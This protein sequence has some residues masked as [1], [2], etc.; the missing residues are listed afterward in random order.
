[1]TDQTDLEISSTDIAI[2]GM[3]GRFPGAADVAE[4]WTTI[5]AG[6]SGI[7]RFTDAELRAAGVA[8]QLLADPSYVKAGAVI[9]G[10]ELFDADFFGVGPREAQILDPQQRLYLEHNW[11]ALEDAGCDPTRFDGAIGVFGGSAWSSYLQHN[12]MPSPTATAMGELVVGLANDKDSLTT[13]VAHTLGLTGPAFSIQSYCSTSLVAVC[14]ASTSLAN[15]ECDLALAGGV[16]VNVPHQVGYLYSEGGIAPPDA[17][18]R[19]FDAAG[20]GAV[21]GSGVG[22]V[23]LR[24][25]SDAVAAGDRI[26]AVIRG[27]AVNNDGG[28]KVGFTAPG[29]QGQAAVIAEALSSADLSAADI[30]YIEA[31]GTG[32]ALGDASEL[33]ALQQVF[34]GQDCLIGS[35][36]TNFGHLDRAAGVTGL[37]KTTLALHRSEIPPTRNLVQ[38][39]PQ[40]AAGEA[41]LEVVTELRS[42]PR[43][44]G[45]VR[46][47][48]VSAFGIGGTNAH[49]VLEEAPVR[50]RPE[51]AARPELLV[52]SARTA[53]AA[54]ARTDG[55][56]AHLAERLADN[57]TGD[58]TGGDQLCDVAHTLQVG[59]RVFEHRRVLVASTTAQ[60]VL[61][62]SE[63]QVLSGAES[64]TDRP[65]GFLIAG[66]G[67][68]YPGMAADLYRD[69]PVFRAALEQCRQILIEQL[70]GLDPL[71]D[72]LSPRRADAQNLSR[73]LGRESAD[74][75]AAAGDQTDRLQPA[76]FAVEY[77]LAQ[78]VLSWGITPSILA[79]YSVGEYV[80]ACLSG[81]L[82][83]ESALSLVAYRATLINSLPAGAMAAVSLSQ[84]ELA[85]SLARAGI[86]GIDVAAVNGRQLT[87]ISGEPASIAAF[88]AFLET[89]SVPCRLLA[90]SHAFHSRMLEPIKA[91]L[92]AWVRE[93]ISL[94]PPQIPYLSN[95]TGT[96][97][98]AEQVTDPAYWAEHM[99]APVLFEAS[100]GVLLEQGDLALLE[101]GPGQSLG[102]MVR[103]H[104]DCPQDRWRR[105]VASLPAAGDPRPAGVV[106]AEMVGRLWLAGVAV[107][108]AG[109][110]QD[111][112]VA[113]LGL[114]GYPFQ[115]ER[116]WIEAPAA[117]AP[118]ALSPVAAAQAAAGP[119]TAQL[120]SEDHVQL[121]SP[122]WLATP[123]S[124]P[125]APP[126]RYILLADAN[127]NADTDA[128][129]VARALAGSLG[130]TGAEPVHAREVSELAELVRTT[131]TGVRATVLD[132]RLLDQQQLE[133]D[134]RELVPAIAEL[135]NACGSDGA[136]DVNIVLVTRGGQLVTPGESPLPGHAGVA[137]LPVVANLEYLNLEC[138]VV[139]LDPAGDVSAA[140]AALAAEL[141]HP[142]AEVLVAYRNG[143]RHLRDFAP[144]LE[145]E[146][147][148][149]LPAVP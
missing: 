45:H 132:L 50:E 57:E 20:Q 94:A 26:Y 105:V 120:D 149:V 75:G 1:M 114:P 117:A 89:E 14:V 131:P 135:I 48:G 109:Y 9:E 23:A 82:S 30:D 2:V 40:L 90:T 15:F 43:A 84:A 77:A 81:V 148:T 121:L 68:Q 122:R 113:K 41:N 144:A 115:R 104:Q 22:V 58:A 24:R 42:W 59:R 7:T 145:S 128:E 86:D 63:K 66:T 74:A 100:L 73:L 88:R 18:C 61:G 71:Q 85:H 60:A 97:A 93:R 140:T 80:A 102:A 31:H 83:L 11:Q 16:A 70:D 38:P 136:S 141:E 110:R 79:G 119:S 29:V 67:E 13:R 96:L 143:L 21:L 118:P 4:L 101:I 33:A 12:L 36:K 95:V 64:R 116:Y 107:D 123:L 37:I 19:A 53:A 129:R 134:G 103:G 146:D 112:P 78:L 137:V 65:V 126:G 124:G 76:T 46:R 39:N 127:A 92:T 62:I 5:R 54:D 147:S 130:R 99:C 6:A 44:A 17:E 69:E 49:V 72:M 91:S 56:A 125:T 47:A 87:V 27:W 35:I 55:L 34:S 25:L 138:R 32:T 8:E 3:S 51:Q 108:W 98:T 28:R 139:D 133:L 106:L 52:W 10:I 111:R 142:A